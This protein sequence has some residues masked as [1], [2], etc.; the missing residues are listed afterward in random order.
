MQTKEIFFIKKIFEKEE[1]ESIIDCCSNFI[2]FSQHLIFITLIYLFTFF[3]NEFSIKNSLI[4]VFGLIAYLFF[5][6][7]KYTNIINN[8]KSFKNR[9]FQFNVLKIMLTKY[10]TTLIK[11]TFSNRDFLIMLLQRMKLSDIFQTLL[12]NPCIKN[13]R[14]EL[15]ISYVF[16]N[17]KLDHADQYYLSRLNLEECFILSPVLKKYRSTITNLKEHAINQL[18]ELIS[19]NIQG[20]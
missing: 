15:I 13:E 20:F 17:I 6:R 1:L 7:K 11:Y 8:R 18:P 9:Y 19:K 16:K 14:K 2:F 12:F 4:L 10:K 3:S 5:G